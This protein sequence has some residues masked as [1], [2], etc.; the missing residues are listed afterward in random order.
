VL[1]SPLLNWKVGVRSTATDQNAVA[2]LGQERSPQPPRQEADLRLRPAANRHHQKS[3]QKMKTCGLAL[4]RNATST[5]AITRWQHVLSVGRWF[6][7]TTDLVWTQLGST[8]T[9][10]GT[11]DTCFIFIFYSK[12]AKISFSKGVQRTFFLSRLT[13]PCFLKH[14]IFPICE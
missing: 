2:L 9:I 10:L 8:S 6:R 3:I 12:F 1:E 14:G 13:I 11:C 4:G 7:K 5:V